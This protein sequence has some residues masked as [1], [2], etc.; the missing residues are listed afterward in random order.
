[1]CVLTACVVLV[2]GSTTGHRRHAALRSSSS[3][4]RYLSLC[5]RVC[6]SISDSCNCTGP[7][8]VTLCCGDRDGQMPAFFVVSLILRD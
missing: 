7:V 2:G 4:S 5:Y 6:P 8:L 1:M 3:S